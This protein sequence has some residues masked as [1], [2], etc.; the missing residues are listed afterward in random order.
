M[1]LVFGFIF[2][3]LLTIIADAGVIPVTFIRHPI[4][5]D[6]AKSTPISVVN[7][8]LPAHRQLPEYFEISSAETNDEIIER[9]NVL[10]VEF[11]DTVEIYAPIYKENEIQLGIIPTAIDSEHTKTCYVGDP[12]AAK[13]LA[14]TLVGNEF[15]EQLVIWAYRIGNETWI[16]PS[17]ENNVQNEHFKNYQSESANIFMLG[18]YTDDGDDENEIVISPCN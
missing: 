2:I 16:D 11:A 6:D 18:S 8:S 7:K 3:S 15:T 12:Q 9:W 17:L 1:R 4:A 10:K 14:L 13:S 5:I